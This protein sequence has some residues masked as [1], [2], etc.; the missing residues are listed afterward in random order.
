MSVLEAADFD[1]QSERELLQPKFYKTFTY[2]PQIKKGAYD[3]EGRLL[4][5]SGC[6]FITNTHTHTLIEHMLLDKYNLSYLPRL[7]YCQSLITMDSSGQFESPIIIRC[8][9]GER[10]G[11]V[12][13]S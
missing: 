10:F 7:V 11:S 1:D 9:M 3:G 2:T 12:L 5:F 4:C 6:S 8:L 13:W